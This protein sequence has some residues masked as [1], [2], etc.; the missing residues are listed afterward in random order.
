VHKNFVIGA[1]LI[2]CICSALCFPGC[3][4]KK[5]IEMKARP[6]AEWVKNA[7]IYQVSLRS[8]S[9]DG[10]FKSLE[11]RL[12]ELKKIGVSVISLLPIHPIGELN[13]RGKLGNP[14]AIKDFYGVNPEFGT[15]DDFKSLIHC[16]HQ[17]NLKIIIS[18]VVHHASWDN[19]ILMEH[20]DW[21]VHDGEGAIVSPE[22]ERYD[23]AQIDF[24]QHEPRKYIIA[25]MKYWVKEIG[26]DGFA[27][28][29]TEAVP[30]D[31]WNVVR[32]ELDQI[33][34]VLMIT[35]E[36]HPAYH[37]EAF[38]LTNSRGVYHAVNHSLMSFEGAS[39]IDDSL[40]REFD[41]FPQESLKLRYV[42]DQD[43]IIE[44]V[45]IQSKRI[46]AVL[47]YTLPGIPRIYNGDEIGITQ[48]LDLFDKAEIDWSQGSELR[49]WYERLGALRTNHIAL[50]CG[51]YT[52]ISNN[53][54]AKVY[55]FLR[56]SGTDSVLLIINVTSEK[57]T[58]DLIVPPSC[59]AT[60]KDQFSI[61]VLQTKDSSLTVHLGPQSF[62]ALTPT[63]GEGIR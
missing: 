39:L 53:D 23:V 46:K 19:Q 30:L 33:K 43:E 41:S 56:A 52:S 58:T 36:S 3:A 24:N 6:S 5:Y 49:V 11:G 1:I 34:S 40:K 29:L 8:F 62:L 12:P 38:D 61:L 50:H 27:F 22:I 26:V 35:D 28:T 21:F 4:K 63:T 15:L 54:P 16:V 2:A 20:P 59:C 9:K 45:N 44:K 25:M 14:Y 57:I 37:L 7:I 47:M 10:T 48:R 51:S 42:S 60:W 13:R 17:Q 55:S 32:K 31:F 18:L